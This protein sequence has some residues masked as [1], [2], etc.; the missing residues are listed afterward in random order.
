MSNE[1]KQPSMTDEEAKKIIEA[2]LFAA[3]HPLTY[4][5]LADVLDKTPAEVKRIVEDYAVWYN[6]EHAKRGVQLLLFDTSCQLCTKEEYQDYVKAALGIKRGGS[7]SASTL[8]VLS[9]IAYHQPVTKAYIEQI[10]GVDSSYAVSNLMD[11][12]LIEVKGRLDV[13][14]KPYLY[15]TTK[16]FLR[17]FGLS[18]LNDLPEIQLFM[19]GVKEEQVEMDVGE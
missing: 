15:V 1:A 16:D 10:R 6:D 5:K 12:A 17:C 2:V 18:S 14:G 4:T 13:P 11:K 7:L 3:G 9:I 19:D 8:E